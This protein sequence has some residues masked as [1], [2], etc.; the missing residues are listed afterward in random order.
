MPTDLVFMLGGE[1][2]MSFIKKFIP[3]LVTQLETAYQEVSESFHGLTRLEWKKEILSFIGDQA[4]AEISSLLNSEASLRSR[5]TAILNIVKVGGQQATQAQ[6]DWINII[7]AI[8]TLP[9]DKQ[10]LYSERLKTISLLSVKAQIAERRGELN[11][12]QRIKHELDAYWNQ[13]IAMAKASHQS[14]QSSLLLALGSFGAL[15]AGMSLLIQRSETPF[16]SGSMSLA[17]VVGTGFF[18]N[19]YVKARKQAG[20]DSQ[21]LGALESC[22]NARLH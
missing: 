19:R 2:L 10:D 11:H 21:I 22:R 5:A 14:M 17:G 3:W 6:S 18:A 8:S 15:L 13:T 1:V 9:P 20:E 16:T 7:K 4:G 12:A